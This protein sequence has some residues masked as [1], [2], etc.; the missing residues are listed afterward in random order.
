MRYVI[1]RDGEQ[2]PVEVQERDGGYLV[3]L[4]GVTH[5]V[6]SREVV[7]GLLS[8]L[9]NGESWEVTVYSPE[10]NFY[11]V[12]LW[13]GMRRVELLSPIDVVMRSQ[14][15]AT[16]GRGLHVRSP[17]PGKVVRVLVAPGQRVSKGDGLVVVEAMK[18]QNELQAQG[19][20][21]VR[22]VRAR[23]GE[24]VEGGVDLV[25]LDPVDGDG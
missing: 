24:N 4:G 14:G 9:V 1:L 12:H 16:A 8:L 20:G 19:D 2:V 6:D 23:E 17:M 11:H 7:P 3:K 25:L 15:G 13:D 18:M 22:E 21:I 10:P 5:E